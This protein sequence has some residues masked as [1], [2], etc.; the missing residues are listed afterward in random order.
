MAVAGKELAISSFFATDF[1]FPD[2]FNELFTICEI[3][4]SLDSPSDLAIARHRL[5]IVESEIRMGLVSVYHAKRILEIKG[6]SADEKTSLIQERIVCLLERRPRDFDHDLF[7]QMQH[8]LVVCSQEFKKCPPICSYEPDHL[9][10]L[11]F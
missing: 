2:F 10:F 5:P 3:V 11:S 1:Q 6:L 4:L 9:C 8:F 7:A